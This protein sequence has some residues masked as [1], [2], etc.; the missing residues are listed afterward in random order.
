MLFNC[1]IQVLIDYDI[2]TQ[3]HLDSACC[4]VND[5]EIQSQLQPSFQPIFAP[6]GDFQRG[7]TRYNNTHT[8]SNIIFGVL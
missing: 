2:E 6:L 5:N 8:H 7:G 1:I 3:S 4:I